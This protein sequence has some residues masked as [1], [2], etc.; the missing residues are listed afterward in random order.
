[1]GIHGFV[2]NILSQFLMQLMKD[3]H[4]PG[5]Q[6]SQV[7]APL[8]AA[9]LPLEQAT[10]ETAPSSSANDP[11]AQTSQLIDPAAAAAEP[12]EQESQV[13]D[14]VLPANDPVGVK[15]LIFLKQMLT[16]YLNSLTL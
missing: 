4:S 8:S 3:L 9:A 1:M 10:Q 14:P 13:T 16:G 12:G 6:A 7:T 11:A 5:T 2:N 15:F